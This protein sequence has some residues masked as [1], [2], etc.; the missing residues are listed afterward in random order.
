VRNVRALFERGATETSSVDVK[1]LVLE[2]NRIVSADARLKK[3]WLSVEVLDSL[4]PLSGNKTHLAQAL[5]N[6]ISNAF[7]SVCDSDGPRE[8]K[9][10]ASA[11]RAEEIRVSVCDSGKGIDANAMHHLFEPFFTTKPTGMG[12]GL[13]IAQSII[14]NHGGRLWATQNPERGAT[15]EFTLPVR[16]SAA[17]PKLQ[18]TAR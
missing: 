9:L 14:Q 5:L 3:I 4:P 17:A 11:E 18:S 8:V 1:E 16:S 15:F 12:M 2:V 6:L 10:R 13:A 7:D